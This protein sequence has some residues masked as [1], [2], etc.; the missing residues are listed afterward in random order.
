MK[1]L[2]LSL[3]VVLLLGLTSA[4]AIDVY[5]IDTGDAL[6]IAVIGKPEYNQSV[7][8]RADG[9]ISYFGGDVAVAGKT[10]EAVRQQ[11]QE[12]LSQRGQLKDPIVMV[13]PIP[14]EGQIFVGGAVKEPGRYPLPL[15][16]AIG[17][18]RA[19]ALAGGTNE[20]AD[21]KQVQIVRLDETVETHDLSPGQP[22]RPITVRASE[23][24]FIPHLGQVDVQGQ[25][26][27]P[28]KIPIQGRIRIDHA[29]ARA[30]GGIND[31]ADLAA[32]VIVR[33]NGETTEV[34]LSEKFWS[35][36][37]DGDE[38]YYLKDGDVLYVPDAYKVEKVYVLGYVR[39]PGP[40]KVRGPITPMQAIALAGG[41]EEDANIDSAKI[42]RKDGS[43]HELNLRR[44]DASDFLLYGGDT[45]EIPKR[46]QINW[47][48]VLSFISVTSVAVG[49][50]LRN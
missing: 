48:F 31:E 10:P 29:L 32:L 22:Y 19:I 13:S 1:H 42:T 34:S 50:F 15:Q 39:N 37:K 18:Y 2:R 45:L 7:T 33:S 9:K 40:Q 4:R 38:N 5:R 28:G 24:V 12:I 17:L 25:V 3:A 26:R 14:R 35:D 44:T 6:L 36:L 16:N 21:L 46:F 49:L 41:T 11:I 47:S 23:L 8:V 20:L 30:G 27:T 43:I